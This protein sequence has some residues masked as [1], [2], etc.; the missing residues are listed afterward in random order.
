M[1]QGHLII[2]GLT[3]KKTKGILFLLTRS[4]SMDVL[5]G[6]NLAMWHDSNSFD[7]RKEFSRS[8]EWRRLTFIYQVIYC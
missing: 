8:D 1:S 4:L 7:F 6:S 2:Y 5:S 3:G